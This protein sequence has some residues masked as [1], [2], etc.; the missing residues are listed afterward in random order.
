MIESRFFTLEAYFDPLL[1]SETLNF[2]L[3]TPESGKD[4]DP[5]L[6]EVPFFCA[7]ISNSLYHWAERYPSRDKPGTLIFELKPSWIFF[8]FYLLAK[9]AYFMIF[10]LIFFK[11]NLKDHEL[12]QAENPSARAKAQ[13]SLAWTYH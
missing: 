12:S 6:N 8:Y 11:L 9:T 4:V 10:N 13:A 5:R 1:I 7:M 3:I 2:A